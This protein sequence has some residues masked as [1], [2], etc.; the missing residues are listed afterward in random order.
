M[1]R[2]RDVGDP[3]ALFDDSLLAGFRQIESGLCG[4][5]SE[6][7]KRQAD[8]EERTNFHVEM[9]PDYFKATREQ[10]SPIARRF[11]TFADQRAVVI[12]STSTGASPGTVAFP[13]IRAGA[14]CASSAFAPTAAPFL[15][16]AGSGM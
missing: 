6:S 9:C 8:C 14:C 5:E 1:I 12:A 7:A 4:S 16:R 15:F 13:M 2:D 3:D 11:R 10:A